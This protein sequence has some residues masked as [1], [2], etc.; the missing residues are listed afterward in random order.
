M[1][2]TFHRRLAA[3]QIVVTGEIAP[4]RGAG[5]AGLEKLAKG[6]RGYVDAVNLTDNQRG[7]A[8]MSAW[9]AGLLLQQNGIETIVQM[10]CQHR[11][12]IALQADVLSGSALGLRNFLCMTGDHPRIGDHPEAKNVLDLNSFQLLRLMRMLRDQSRFHSG[13]ALKDAPRYLIGGVANPNIEKAARLEKKIES[14]AE[15]IQTQLVFDVGRFRQ[16][17]ADVRAAGLH[18]GAY[19]L[20]GVMLLRSAQSALFLRD[21]LPGTLMPDCTIERMEHAADP[22]AEGIAQAAELVGELLSVEGV[23][24]VHLMSVN[25]TR[26]MPKV[27]ERAGLLPRPVA[28]E[29]SAEC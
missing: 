23:A 4:P 7:V 13:V 28:P 11:N 3:G 6:L 27:I 19:I 29:A 26:G 10:T 2:S 9:G 22:E 14:G 18:K 21:H 12:R 17:M 8:R 15:F 20:A 16:W 1:Y 5:G 24:G 25:W